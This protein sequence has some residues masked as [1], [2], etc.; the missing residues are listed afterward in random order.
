MSYKKTKRSVEHLVWKELE[1][2]QENHG[3]TFHSNHEG[4]AV[5]Y[6]EICEA[7][8]EYELMTDKWDDFWKS[9][10]ADDE[11]RFIRLKASR[12]GRRAVALACEAIQV[13]AMCAKLMEVEY[14]GTQV[15]NG[16]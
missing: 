16:E 14:D 7:T 13:A 11:D 1:Y 9:V 6:E 15:P 3:K 12:I 4:A 5:I 10:M 8:A 2:A